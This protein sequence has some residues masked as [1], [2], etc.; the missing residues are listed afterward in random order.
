LLVQVGYA[1]ASTNAIARRAGV[2]IGSLYQYFTDKDALFR[3]VAE[4]HRNEVKPLIQ[5]ALT[6][7]GN[8]ANDLVEVTLQLM[9]DM[10]RVN[11]NNPKLM[12]AI[13]SELGWLERENDANAQAVQVLQQVLATRY[14]MP[15][16]QLETIALLLVMTVSQLSRWLVHGKPQ[17]L[18]SEP[19]ITATGDML[20]AILPS[21]APA[22][23]PVATI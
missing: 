20:R 12:A 16:Q 17:H 5:T 18:A 2:S 14:R 4:R 1:K 19:F 13:E 22:L 23:R 10:A 6:E 11:A 9:R 8:P 15:R 7:L 21:N 3:A